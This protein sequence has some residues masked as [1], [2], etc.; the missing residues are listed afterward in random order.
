MIRL[1]SPKNNT[2]YRKQIGLVLPEHSPCNDR[3]EPPVKAAHM[4][5]G[6][7]MHPPHSIPPGWGGANPFSHKHFFGRSISSFR[8]KEAD[9]FPR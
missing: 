6:S 7:E 4:D 8:R 2:A 1:N 3:A 9:N 5:P